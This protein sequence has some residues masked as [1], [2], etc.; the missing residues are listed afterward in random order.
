MSPT[1]RSRL[2]ITLLVLLLVIPLALWAVISPPPNLTN[3]PNFFR[4][5]GQITAIIGFVLFAIQFVLTARFNLIE[6]LLSGLNKVY[7][8]HHLIGGLA[9]VFLLVHPISLAL[10]YLAFSSQAVFDFLKPSTAEIGKFFGTLALNLLVILLLLTYIRHLKYHT[11]KK[12]HQFMGIPFMLGFIHV[13]LVPGMLAQNAPLKAYLLIV[14]LMGTFSYIY[15][16]LVKAHILKKKVATV[17]KIKSLSASVTEIILK[18]DTA[19]TYQ[20]G[21]FIF[22]SFKSHRVSQETHPF[23]LTS[24][25]QGSHISLGIKALGDYTTHIKNI[26]MGDKA[27]IDGPYGHFTQERISF[28]NQIWIAGGIGITPFIGFLRSLRSQI[29]APLKKVHL[30]YAVANQQEAAYL[31]ELTR[32]TRNLPWLTVTIHQSTKLG[33][34]TINTIKQK[35]NKIENYHL[36]I[37]GPLPMMT[38]LKTQA[39]SLGIPTSNIHS[40]EFKLRD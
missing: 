7:F 22:I 21:Q 39:K 18:P 36:L 20:A 28:P 40:E 15:Q 12:T 9:L 8:W 17:V 14:G 27:E 2:A 34:L 19:F 30:F 23:S 24:D 38:A 1:G 33:R 32:A 11:W 29:S 6:N 37:C 10:Q 13:M 3:A 35:I 5:L 16:T 26:K 25:P 4:A 31:P